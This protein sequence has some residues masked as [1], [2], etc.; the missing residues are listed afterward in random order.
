MLNKPYDVVSLRTHQASSRHSGRP[1]RDGSPAFELNVTQISSHV[2][3][4]II[5]VKHNF[6]IY[7]CFYLISSSY[8]FRPFIWPS[9][10]YLG[11]CVFPIYIIIFTI[12]LYLYYNYNCYKRSL[13]VKLCFTEN[14]IPLTYN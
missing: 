6:T 11:E 10:S 14:T 1:K 5:S 4:M 8:M 12:H 9:S 3:V 2:K 13:I 7:W